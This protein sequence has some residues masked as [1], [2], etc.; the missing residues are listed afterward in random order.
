MGKM[1]VRPKI[2]CHGGAGKRRRGWHEAQAAVEYAAKEGYKVLKKGGSA[3]DAVTC[4]VSAM[5]DAPVLNA[6][7]GSYVQLDGFARMDACIMDSKL[8]VGSVIQIGD[9]KNPIQ[10]ARKILELKIHS[11]LMGELASNF[12]REHGFPIYDPRTE[13]RIEQWLKIRRKFAKYHWH[14]LIMYLKEEAYRKDKLSTVG[15]VA[16]DK[17]G[18]L[19][20]GTST[21]GLQ[22]DLPGRVGDVPLVGCGNYA[23]KYGAVSCTGVGEKIIKVVL[24]KSVTD[25]MEYGMRAQ[26][27]CNKGMKLIDLV[28]GRAGLIAVDA[29]GN[30]G[31]ACNSPFMSFSVV[32]DE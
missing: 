26:E 6:G 14:D 20:A 12:A 28:K 30:V 7:T 16:I 13:Q 24:A 25:F 5:E 29:N 11:V 23:C 1:K 10:V 2:I 22:I 19:A 15:A 21:G 31:W 17:D 3:L 32:G 4:A 8:N 27:A 18:K 9:V